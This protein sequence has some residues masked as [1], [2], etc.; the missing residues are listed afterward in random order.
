M[1]EKGTRLLERDD[2][3]EFR[4]LTAAEL[5]ELR[6][7][8][9]HPVAALAAGFQLRKSGVENSFLGFDETLE[10]VRIAH[11]AHHGPIAAGGKGRLARLLPRREQPRH[12]VEENH[13]RTGHQ[14][15]GDEPQADNG[16]VDTGVIGETGGDAHDL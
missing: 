12:N 11:I 2:T 14:R 15:K 13:Y 1:L 8:E 6:E 9:P 16:R 5:G 10:I 4:S 3:V 7:D